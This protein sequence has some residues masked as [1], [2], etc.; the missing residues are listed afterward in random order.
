MDRLRASLRDRD[1]V[2][3]DTLPCKLG[4]CARSGDHDLPHRLGM[5]NDRV[6][7]A[8]DAR[9]RIIARERSGLD[10]SEDVVRATALRDRERHELLDTSAI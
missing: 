8:R 1:E 2:G 9:E 6:G 5:T 4:A 3:E 7:D 10:A